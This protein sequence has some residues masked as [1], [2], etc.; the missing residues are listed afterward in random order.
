MIMDDLELPRWA[1]LR[2]L[3][4]RARRRRLRVLYLK[5][6]EGR[7]PDPGNTLE[8]EHQDSLERKR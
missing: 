6:S 8:A 5:W 7:C 1:L 4:R 2:R 3:Q